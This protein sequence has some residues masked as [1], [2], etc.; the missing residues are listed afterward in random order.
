MPKEFVLPDLGEG[1]AEAQI[2]KLLVAPGDCTAD[3]GVGIHDFANFGDCMAGPGG[4][5]GSGRCN[6]LDLDGDG[7]VDLVDMAELQAT[8]IGE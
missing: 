3:G 2:V 8:F 7:D 6:C 5:P 4:E 1:I